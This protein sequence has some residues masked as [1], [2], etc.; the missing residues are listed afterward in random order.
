M[1]GIEGA[2]TFLECDTVLPAK[3]SV[4]RAVNVA[5]EMIG[6]FISGLLVTVYRTEFR[7]P[8]KRHPYFAPN[9]AGG[10]VGFSPAG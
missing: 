4:L 2:F 1:D 10:W 5:A 6:S 3:Q 9:R 8:V 7:R